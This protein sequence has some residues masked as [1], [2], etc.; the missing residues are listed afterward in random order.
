[1]NTKIYFRIRKTNHDESWSF[2]V[3]IVGVLWYVLFKL[4][5]FG[6]LSRTNTQTRLCFFLS[7]PSLIIALALKAVI[8][9]KKINQMFNWKLKQIS[10]QVPLPDVFVTTFPDPVLKQN[11]TTHQALLESDIVSWVGWDKSKVRLN[12][13][14]PPQM[15]QK[16]TG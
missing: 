2:T 15:R 9:K 5:F 12:S 7:H 1:M 8:R 10:I 4:D 14:K 16:D 11:N 6:A 13:M 3:W